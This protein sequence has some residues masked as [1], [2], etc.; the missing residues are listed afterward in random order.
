MHDIDDL[1]KLWQGCHC[2]PCHVSMQ[3]S[4]PNP[5][6]PT[7]VLYC[8]RI[9]IHENTHCLGAVLPCHSSNGLRDCW[10]HRP[11]GLWPHDHAN[12]VG[13]CRCGQLGILR[14][15]DSAYLYQCCGPILVRVSTGRF[16]PLLVAVL[17]S[18]DTMPPVMTFQCTS[19]IV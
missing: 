16:L 2:L 1:K 11:L 4:H 5:S 18:Y 3:L 15:G 14:T 7:P 13:T 8:A 12:E 17:G 10:R 6:L 19:L 9:F